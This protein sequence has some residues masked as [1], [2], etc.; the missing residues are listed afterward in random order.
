MKP[1][2]AVAG[3]LASLRCALVSLPLTIS[4]RI[5]V[6]LF[7]V[8]VGTNHFP[9][10]QLWNIPLVEGFPTSTLLTFQ[11]IILCCDGLAGALQDD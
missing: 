8:S 11:W 2:F 4:I 10:L 3:D 5:N 6:D 1:V 7:I 9:I